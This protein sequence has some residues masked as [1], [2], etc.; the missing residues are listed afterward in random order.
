MVSDKMK[1]IQFFN[2]SINKDGQVWSHFFN[3][4]L[5]QQ[6]DKQGYKT[7]K[8]Y[9]DGDGTY[10]RYKI[11]RLVAITYIPNPNNLLQV[12]HKDGNKQNNHV[13]NLEWV[14]PKENTQHYWSELH[15]K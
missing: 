13:D 10:K 12:N 4:F 8:L 7:I 6:T 1:R 5:K 15:G 2:Y 14:T 3:K 9:D 11:H